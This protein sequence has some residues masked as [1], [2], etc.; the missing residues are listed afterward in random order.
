MMVVRRLLSMRWI[1]ACFAVATLVGM[2]PAGAGVLNK[3]DRLAELDV[4]VDASGK[5][6]KLRKLKNQWVLVTVGAA[7]CKP[8]AKELPTW[9]KLAG[10]MKGKITFI[11][12]SVDDDPADGKKFHKRLKLR[13]M[14]LVYMPADKS[15][16]AARYGSDT[17]PSS[18]VADKNHVIKLRKDGFA[19]RDADG[20]LKKMHV[21]LDKL[22]K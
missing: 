18:F 12:I 6:F 11:A 21:Q 1:L 13:N 19:E 22:I 3:G 14:K 16:I 17:M 7:W 4:A 10:I 9:D 5:P 2:R 20:E 15:A 8:C